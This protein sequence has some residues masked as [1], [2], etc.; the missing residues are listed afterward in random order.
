MI[1]R[2]TRQ[3]LVIGG[4]SRLGRAMCDQLGDDVIVKTRES[5]DITDF[6]TTREVMALLRPD[7]VVNTAA[8]TDWIAA[9]RDTERC[10]ETNVLAVQNLAEVCSDL[11]LPLLQVSDARVFGTT[12]E[13]K[14]PHKERSATDAVNF[15]AQSKLAG[16]AAITK[17]ARRRGLKYWI[18]RTSHI[19]ERP[20]RQSR[21]PLYRLLSVGK[22]AEPVKMVHDVECSPTYAPH[23][24]AAVIHLMDVRDKVRSGIYHIANKGVISVRGLGLELIRNSGMA[25]TV[26]TLDTAALC[27]SN[28]LPKEA[29]PRY[30]ALDT[31]KFEKE[32]NYTMPTWR[33]GVKAYLADWES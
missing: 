6:D 12:P 24:A 7:V 29:W 20:W 17:V 2:K 21:E 1:S 5:L 30:T 22:H 3:Y 9:E 10:W 8:Y 23:L 11:E 28:G 16:E 33:E 4:N 19:Y 32:C 27:E 15:Y 14:K 31:S 26:G 18:V 13:I 25:L